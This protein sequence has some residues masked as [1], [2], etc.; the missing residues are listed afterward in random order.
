MIRLRIKM[1][2]VFCYCANGWFGK[3]ISDTTS[4]KRDHCMTPTG[5]ASHEYEDDDDEEEE[6]T[7]GGMRYRSC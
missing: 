3:K 5:I 4:S 7:M 6:E 1:M 2:K